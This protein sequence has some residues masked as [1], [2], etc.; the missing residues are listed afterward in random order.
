M[1]ERKIVSGERDLFR[2][3]QKEIE[4]IP[5]LKREEEVVIARQAC[6]GDQVSA[7]RIIESNLRFVLKVVFSC[8]RP[9][10]PLMDLISEGCRGLI[11]ALQT[12]DPDK[13]FRFITYAEPWITSFVK[14]AILSHR[15]HEHISL[16]EPAYDDGEETTLKDLL[17]SGE[18]GADEAVSNK[19]VRR[20]L[21]QLNDRERTIIILRFWQDLTLE[22]IG[23]RIGIKKESVRRVESRTLRKLRWEH[24]SGYGG[25]SED[26]LE[27]TGPEGCNV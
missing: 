17:I 24:Y 3:F 10:L 1:K 2:M 18:T 25:H 6:A 7:D 9:D 8:W 13:G 19:E 27:I 15:R 16:D 26:H 14:R 4:N 21:L 12:F 23:L 20:I 5:V 22:E 11:R